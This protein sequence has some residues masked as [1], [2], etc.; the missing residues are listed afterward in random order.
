MGYKRQRVALDMIALMLVARETA[1][2][3][4]S[5][6]LGGDVRPVRLVLGLA[7]G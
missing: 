7:A 4:S 1:S 3:S 5:S 2:L 6:G